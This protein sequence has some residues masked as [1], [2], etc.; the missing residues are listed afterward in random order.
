M[1][2]IATVHRIVLLMQLAMFA[3]VSGGEGEGRGTRPLFCSVEIKLNG[4][5][6][7]CGRLS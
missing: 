1:E 7:A 4:S 2:L 5:L 3:T 6:D